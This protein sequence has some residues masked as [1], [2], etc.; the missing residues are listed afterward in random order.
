MT[1]HIPLM[2]FFARIIWWWHLAVG[3]IILLT[4]CGSRDDAAKTK[5]FQAKAEELRLENDRLT[6]EVANLQLNIKGVG[7]SGPKFLAVWEVKEKEALSQALQL[8]KLVEGLQEATNQ[9]SDEKQT[10]QSKYTAP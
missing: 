9:L 10:Y 1:Q 6:A 5:E 4:S 7:M 8:Q 2:N 3:T